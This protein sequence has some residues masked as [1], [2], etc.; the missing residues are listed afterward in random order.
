VSILDDIFTILDFEK[1]IYYSSEL[2]P[3]DPSNN[4]NIGENT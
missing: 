3:N 4:Q 2:Y 1:V